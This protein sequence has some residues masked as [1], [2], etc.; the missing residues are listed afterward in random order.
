MGR[1]KERE[2]EAEKDSCR[3][4]EGADLLIMKT[5]DNEDSTDHPGHL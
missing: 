4:G 1:D 3:R 5:E 2:R